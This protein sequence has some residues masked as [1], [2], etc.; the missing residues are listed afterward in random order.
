MR[1]IFMLI[2]MVL[3]VQWISSQSTNTVRNEYIIHLKNN[4]TA[5]QAFQSAHRNSIGAQFEPICTAPLALM[6]VTFANEK[7]FRQFIEKVSENTD[8]L[9]IYPN[10]I[11]TPRKTPDDPEFSNQWQYINTG[12]NGGKVG[13]D[14]DMDQAW[15]ICT[16][17]L[18]PL[19]DTIVVCVVDDG[20][21]ASH[22]D[23]KG[24]IWY[25]YHEIP[26]NG[27]DDDGNGYIDD[28]KGYNVN[29][30]NDNVHDS[31]SHGTPVAGIIGARGNNGIGVSGINW[32]IKL[33][34]VNYGI[35]D[36][37]HA[38]AAYAY[39]YQMRKLYNETNGQKGAFVV[40]TNT[41]WGS[42]NLFA[43]D[44][45]LWCAMYDSLG[46]V[47][48]LNVAATTNSNT[49]VDVFGDMPTSCESE[50]LISVTNINNKDLKVAGAGYGRKS[51][52]LGGFGNQAYNITSN[53]YGAFSG[54]SSACPHVTGVAA[55]AYNVPCEEFAHL[56]KTHP[57]Q[58]ALIVKDMI[59]NGATYNESLLGIT[60]T[61]GRI[62]AHRALQNMM[63]L[64]DPCFPPS[65]ITISKNGKSITINWL[66][67][68]SSTTNLR[69]RP[70]DELAWRVINDVQNGI[71]IDSLDFCREYEI[72]L[73]ND[74]G[75]FP[76]DYGYSKFI[77]TDGCCYPPSTYTISALLDTISVSWNGQ[78]NTLFDV[79][80]RPFGGDWEVYQTDTSYLNISTIDNCSQYEIFVES[81][82]LDFGSISVPGKMITINSTCGACTEQD[83]CTFLKK[84][85]SQEWIDTIFIN[86]DA[87]PSG[88]FTGGY[89][90]SSGINTSILQAGTQLSFKMNIG[91]FSSQFLEYVSV[92]CDWNQDGSF[93]EDELS[94]QSENPSRNLIEGTIDIPA[95]ALK[96]TTRMR[97]LMSY[98][99]L[100]SPCDDI[101]FNYGE[102]NDICVHISDDNCGSPSSVA[103][104][105]E[106][107]NL[108]NIHNNE[109]DSLLILYRDTSELLWK[110]AIIA[111]SSMLSGFD[112]CS[113][114]FIKYSKICDGRYAPLSDVHSIKTQCIN[115]VQQVSDEPISIFPNPSQTNVW[116]NNPQPD[117][118]DIFV[119]DVLGRTYNLLYL[120]ENDRIKVD[121][122]SLQTGYHVMTL[123]SKGGY[124]YHLPFIKSP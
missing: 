19:G 32:N 77:T 28:F 52:D 46:K 41:S 34:A 66:N 47:G 109:G 42:D 71:V 16:G 58:A 2:Y 8:V 105:I 94:Y 87:Y 57:D 24:N 78:K 3:G 115:A 86:G 29:L 14:M 95:N 101:N 98:E 7:S 55:L 31:G 117:I 25:N 81:Q 1:Y 39:P 90:L 63:K 44:A 61:Q 114:I 111:H 43:K 82:C 110:K 120:R 118:S 60:T 69:Y 93:S 6:K 51:I 91:Y 112:S 80:I 116:I 102:V 79:H 54:T 121:I 23:L 18:S 106:G 65:G 22:P 99:S 12:Q 62:N 96:G 113:V 9:G 88:A 124:V 40:A 48:I 53:S 122:T 15:D 37:A 5:F 119:T 64:C 4:T 49:D 30:D 33:M 104:T 73:T 100:D 45:P 83:Y 59:L 85:N 26:N 10:H 13:A 27:I 97:F 103:F 67:S 74:C 36:E 84:D 56:T 72:Q 75:L 107:D 17:G 70:I 89:L 50:F 20:I 38:L 108:I 11:I 68:E 76:T 123:R 21:K 92:Y 35:A